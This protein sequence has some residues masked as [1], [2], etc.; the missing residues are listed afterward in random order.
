MINILF[1]YNGIPQNGGTEAVMMNYYRRIDRDR[2]SVNFLF[3]GSQEQCSGNPFCEQVLSTGGRIFFVTPRGEDF[4]R[5]R[6]E[7]AQ[8]FAE[9]RYDIVHCHMDSAASFVLKLA[10]KAG[11][12]VRA[13]H[14]HSTGDHF[15]MK[16]TE[17]ANTVYRVILAHA[18]RQTAREANLRFACSD[19][20][21]KWLYGSRPFTVINNGVDCEHFAFSEEKRRRIRD[22]LGLSD[23][24]VIGHV[25]RLSR[26]KNQNKLLDVFAAVHKERPDS[27]LVMV[28]SGE[29]H[30]PISERVKSEF[31]DRSV[32]LTGARSDSD[33]LLSAFDVFVMPSLYEGLSVAAVEAQAAGLPCVLSDTV[34]KQV[35]LTENV[36]FLPLDAS[37]ETWSREV[38]RMSA[39]ERK[40]TREDIRAAG[41]DSEQVVR[42]LEK[43]YESALAQAERSAR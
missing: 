38:L 18:R 16:S 3:H 39:L 7:V 17:L 15:I 35:K 31:P 25:G 1:A 20:A 37:G 24:L 43:A 21:G 14:S 23:K 2:F 41:F 29:D 32:I 12:P 11:V 28:G 33:C 42:E 26:V 30:D 6:R 19:A 5:N 10:K 4:M 13:A 9:N 22:E 34:T 27:A 40:Y 36:C 8:I